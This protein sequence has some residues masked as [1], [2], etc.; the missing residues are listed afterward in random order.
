[1]HTHGLSIL[2]ESIK[3]MKHSKRKKYS[4]INYILNLA[5]NMT[6]E[7]NVFEILKSSL[8]RSVWK[9]QKKKVVKK[10]DELISFVCNV[11]RS[12]YA[13]APDYWCNYAHDANP[14]QV[15]CYGNIIIV[16]NGDK[17]QQFSRFDRELLLVHTF[18][19]DKT[20]FEICVCCQ[21]EKSN[22]KRIEN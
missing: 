13:N 14:L 11:F 12:N 16:E 17:E 15:K 21:K 10:V 4:N 18:V 9:Y 2:R 7:K 20:M 5:R 3:K 8:V 19:L 6:S 1:M 22:Y